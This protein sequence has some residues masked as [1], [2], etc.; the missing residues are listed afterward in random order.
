MSCS[1]PAAWPGRSGSSQKPAAPA[2]RPAAPAQRPAAPA[3][4]PAAQD[5]RP[6]APGLAPGRAGVRLGST[7]PL[8]VLDLGRSAPPAEAAAALSAGDRELPPGT[9]AIR[10][11]MQGTIVSF[12]V[13][14]GR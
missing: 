10:A 12:N 2:Q 6:A 14:A 5:Q 9:V 1:P 4:K 11:P 13:G 8:A 3:Q 7:D